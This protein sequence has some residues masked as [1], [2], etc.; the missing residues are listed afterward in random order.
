MATHKDKFLKKNYKKL[1][2][3]Y[4]E[5]SNSYQKK[6][7]QLKNEIS[8]NFSNSISKPYT[9]L[10][11]ISKE[12]SLLDINK[13]STKG[14]SKVLKKFQK[15]LDSYSYILNS[16]H[17]DKAIRGKIYKQTH[18]SVSPKKMAKQF[19]DAQ[20]MAN[21]FCLEN[22]SQP[23]SKLSSN[24]LRKPRKH[25]K[26][27]D[28]DNLDNED[29][30]FPKSIE[31]IIKEHDD[32]NTPM[33]THYKKPYY[34]TN[35]PLKGSNPKISS[36]SQG[37]SR[38]NSRHYSAY[39]NM[40][41]KVPDDPLRMTNIDLNTS[42]RNFA[43]RVNSTKKS[44]SLRKS[45]IKKSK[46]EKADSNDFITDEQ[47]SSPHHSFCVKSVG[48][49]SFYINNEESNLKLIKMEPEKLDSDLTLP[50][51]NKT[52]IENTDSL[53]KLP[54][55]SIPDKAVSKNMKLETNLSM[56]KK[57]LATN[58]DN[59]ISNNDVSGFSKSRKKSLTKFRSGRKS[60]SHHRGSPT[61]IRKLKNPGYKNSQ[62]RL[63]DYLKDGSHK[64]LLNL[65]SMNSQNTD[66][67]NL[68]EEK[69]G[70]KG[71]IYKYE[72]FEQVS[73]ITR[74]SFG[75]I[76]LVRHIKT[77][78]PFV[79]KRIPQSS[80]KKD[81][82]IQHLQSEKKI[83]LNTEIKKDFIIQCYDSF[84]DA[85]NLYFVM[86]F[87]PGGDLHDMIKKAAFASLEKVKFYFSEVVLAIEELHRHNIVHRDLKL[88]NIMIGADGHVKLV[89]F[90]FAKHL[91]SQSSKAK[92]KCGTP[93]YLP[94]EVIRGIGSDLRSD[95]WSL[96]VLLCEMIGGFT[97]FRASDPQNLYDNVLNLNITWPRN[98]DKISKDLI[99]KILVCEPEMRITIPDMKEHIF[100]KN[101]DWESLEEKKVSP[102]L[103][104]DLEDEFSLEYFKDDKKMEMYNNPLYEFDQKA[105]INPSPVPD[106]DQ[107]FNDF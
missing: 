9:N 26:F 19:R 13:E 91:R 27:D 60:H 31:N 97:P 11:N 79:F 5:Y 39:K 21:S 44:N 62:I 100:F 87:I 6:I 3:K 51:I 16:K 41:N 68:N 40:Q 94:P 37:K 17:K 1:N 61:K 58:L 25:E 48:N 93:D 98:I 29:I 71:S 57:N 82:Q 103:V 55:E 77:Q 8:Y 20:G 24:S 101:I 36:G 42:Q 15:N 85:E 23:N 75:I 96:G 73:T 30:N 28:L 38:V 18:H 76:E 56:I 34:N 67:K 64:D 46:L 66:S 102:P 14:K 2:Q 35:R 69:K 12:G 63:K 105:G 104:P 65:T 107:Y 59:K 83:C 52:Q 49:K 10:P 84:E 7:D 47:S 90:G 81:K 70:Y 95:I 92:T 22:T 4:E 45:P 50:S 88:D 54:S 78:K 43:I 53:V 74:G 106:F 99:S 80:V 86:E 89:D 72:D 32:D 33:R